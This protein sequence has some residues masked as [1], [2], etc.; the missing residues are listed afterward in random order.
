MCDQSCLPPTY[1]SECFCTQFY[2]IYIEASNGFP[3]AWVFGTSGILVFIGVGSIITYFLV[4]RSN[5]NGNQNCLRVIFRRRNGQEDDA[6]IEN[7]QN[8]AVIHNNGSESENDENDDGSE[9]TGYVSPPPPYV[10]TAPPA[11][12]LVNLGPLVHEDRVE[13]M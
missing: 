12:P 11:S 6:L 13:R 9:G 5:A 2:K 8:Q 1:C 4:R 7:D 3:F 10:P